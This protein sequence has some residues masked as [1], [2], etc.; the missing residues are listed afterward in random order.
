MISNA[1]SQSGMAS[2]DIERPHPW[3]VN[4]YFDFF[5]IFG[6]AVWVFMAVNYLFLGWTVP[7][8]ATVGSSMSRILMVIGLIG[9][10]IIANSHNAATYMRIYGSDHDYKRFKFYATWL[11]FSCLP[12][13]CF[14]IGIP[15]LAGV[16][17]YVYLIT[18][19]WHYS[20]QTFGIAL[21]YCHKQGYTLKKYE[22]ETFRWLMLAASLFV[23][24]RTLTYKEFSP[25]NFFG[26]QC[27]FWGP[28]PEWILHAIEATTVGLIIASV[29]IVI[30]KLIVEK[31]FIPF[32]VLMAAGTLAF[33]CLSTGT[34]NA[35]VWF[36]VP[37]F[38][39]GSQYLAVCLAYHI[40]ENNLPAWQSSR[41][42][43]SLFLKRESLN[44]LGLAVLVGAFLYV[45]IPSIF[46]QL[47]F[48]YALV[49][50]VVLGVVNYHHFIT[51]AA[52]WKLN[53][54]ETRKLLLA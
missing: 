54:S 38:F 49:G 27:P 36:Y 29:L 51:D 39:H 3:I 2:F 19:F 10:H 9:Q 1:I 45:V 46:Q 24:V 14:G 42:V 26:V 20:A 28:L 22:K 35:M 37:V 25:R 30:K 53:D 21:I 4:L 8:S 32:P 23:A 50:G 11:A 48:D 44:Y 41:D 12:L 52:I 5:F 6:G 7:L 18:V 33:I 40:K 15:G 16:F 34:A 47:G 17:V 43:V 13:F 31:V